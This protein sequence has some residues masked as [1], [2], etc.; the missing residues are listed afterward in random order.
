MGIKPSV[1]HFSCGSTSAVAT[2]IEICDNPNTE[3]LYADP[4]A[5][6]PDNKRFLR[7]FEQFIKRKITIVKSKKY[8][9]IFEV[10]EDRK[11]LAGIVDID[12]DSD[13]SDTFGMSVNDIPTN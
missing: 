11:Y 1:C 7:D 6:H 2:L 8:N 12:I 4:A 13:T 5:E 3:V 10:F 9:N